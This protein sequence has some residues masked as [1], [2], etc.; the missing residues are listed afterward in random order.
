MSIIPIDHSY[1]FHIFLNCLSIP[2]PSETSDKIAMFINPIIIV[3]IFSVLAV[4]LESSLLL[5]CYGTCCNIST[6]Q[7]NGWSNLTK[8]LTFTDLMMLD[9]PHVHYYKVQHI[10]VLFAEGRGND[11]L[12]SSHVTLTGEFCQDVVVPTKSRHHHI[13]TVLHPV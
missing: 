7:Q 5:D 1:F 9:P 4:K 8:F 11:I 6:R 10:L 3:L 12:V 13:L 2:I